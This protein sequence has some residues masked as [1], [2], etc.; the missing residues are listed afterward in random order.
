MIIHDGKR[1]RGISQREGFF[2]FRYTDARG[3]E[4]RVRVQ[5]IHE[6]LKLYHEKRDMKRK[7]GMPAP[8]VLRRNKVMFEELARDAL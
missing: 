5:T 7:G 2:V 8:I 4:H 1:Y 3:N 6:A